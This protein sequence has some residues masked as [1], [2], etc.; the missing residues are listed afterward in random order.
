MSSTS[1]Y[2]LEKL[3]QN[4]LWTTTLRQPT[5]VQKE[6][7]QAI[8]QVTKKMF[9]S[10]S[11]T[12]VATS[13]FTATAAAAASFSST[14]TSTKGGVLSTLVDS[15]AAGG[16]GTGASPGA[17]KGLEITPPKEW[18]EGAGAIQTLATQELAKRTLKS[19]QQEVFCPN[20]S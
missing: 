5:T 20:A 14:S 2:I 15:S 7:V 1:R 9:S 6:Q 12:G 16:G 11:P 4:Y 10:A 18:Q 19:V 13:T 17:M 8:E 3:T